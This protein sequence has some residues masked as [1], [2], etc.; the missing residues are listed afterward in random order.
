MLTDKALKRGNTERQTE[1]RLLQIIMED[2]NRNAIENGYLL[3]I[4]QSQHIFLVLYYL[5][6][7]G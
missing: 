5:Y 7:E 1:R 4:G 2:T 6:A 3:Y